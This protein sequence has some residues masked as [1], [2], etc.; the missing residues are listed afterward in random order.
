M[1]DV[2]VGFGL[3]RRI[4]RHPSKA[5]SGPR[6]RE[7]SRRRIFMRRAAVADSGSHAICQVRTLTLISRECTRQQPVEF[8]AADSGLIPENACGVCQERTLA[9]APRECLRLTPHVD[10]G[11][12]L[13]C[14]KN[15][16]RSP[17]PCVTVS[18]PHSSRYVGA[19]EICG[20]GSG[21]L[22]LWSDA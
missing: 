16:R 4:P 22:T 11:L 21:A 8:I 18:S 10:C 7:C 14:P 6:F 15:A 5:D 13:S 2:R 20:V 3:C 19:C 9:L 17:V 1:I 12:G